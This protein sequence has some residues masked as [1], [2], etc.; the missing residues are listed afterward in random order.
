MRK[1]LILVVAILMG[2]AHT[3]P[4][5]ER[6]QLHKLTFRELF[7]RALKAKGD[8]YVKLRN[9]I[10]G[11]NE[12]A[13]PFLKVK[14]CDQDWRTAILA[15]AMLGRITDL[16]R[17]THYKELLIV[18]IKSAWLLEEGTVV[19]PRPFDDIR[20]IAKGQWGWR[21]RSYGEDYGEDNVIIFDRA[22]HQE[23]AI[24]FLIELVLKDSLKKLP[25]LTSRIPWTESETAY[26]CKEVAELLQITEK[27]AICWCGTRE[28]LP[29]GKNGKVL[30]R[31]VAAFV[32]RYSKST[33]R[34]YY[35][36]NL[37]RCYAVIRLG[38]FEYPAIIPA[39]IESLKTDDN[40]HVR[41]Y[42][43]EQLYDQEAIKHL[44][45]ALNDRDSIV[46]EAAAKTLGVLKDI[47]SVPHLM[48]MLNDKSYDVKR[49]AATAL[50]DINDL[51]SVQSLLNAMANSSPSVREAAATALAKIKFE[52]LK[53]ALRHE[54]PT[55]RE[56]ASQAMRRLKFQTSLKYLVEDYISDMDSHIE[57][58]R[59]Q[60][61]LIRHNAAKTLAET[62]MQV[63][64]SALGDK[65]K[66]AR[67][68]AAEMLGEKRYGR[69]LDAL[70]NILADE[71]P[72]VRSAAAGALG[73]IR[74]PKA[75][76]A[77]IDRLRDS[78][79]GVRKNVVGAL[80]EIGDSRAVGPIVMVLQK[81]K[82]ESLRSSA[83]VSLAKIKHPRALNPLCEALSDNNK[84]IRAMAARFLGYL[85]DSRA[86]GP[87][88]DVLDD[89]DM[90]IRRMA[91]SG[92]AKIGAEAVSHALKHKDPQVRR[93]ALS[94]LQRHPDP[95]CFELIITAL[96]DSDPDVRS[97]AISS[98]SERMSRFGSD[99]QAL[100]AV[101][102]KVKDKYPQVRRSALS[103]LS[104]WLKNDSVPYLIVGLKDSN[105]DVRDSVTFSLGNL[106]DQ[107]A[108]YPLVE[109]LIE[110]RDERVKERMRRALWQI[111]G[112]DSSPEEWRQWWDESSKHFE[113]IGPGQVSTRKQG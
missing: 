101:I 113:D 32:G 59:D 41:A 76:E 74:D 21:S 65:S 7:D 24:P 49:A 20:V 17:Y 106:K 78:D 109:A 23:D 112:N 29:L 15:E 87:L 94:E 91:V 77:L 102:N 93:A 42:A 71:S 66:L 92:L 111:T 45:E 107:R 81:H 110:E 5:T 69:A 35:N 12:G 40:A 99:K 36:R 84:H 61:W 54:N 34:N 88:V 28:L 100:E 55:I 95:N 85:E 97:M 83:I 16:E 2:S 1:I 96:E 26:S 105:R 37:A 57:S 53:D 68:I 31:D 44:R 48:D 3:V 80:G 22:L 13:V 50:G 72:R 64:V 75:T 79:S 90:H 9:A 47:E 18:P 58:L 108:V 14:V 63:L 8:E 27:T 82:D 39:L 56:S 62:N 51:K 89:E 4:G 67:E 103:A 25:A 10:I 52:T 33:I 86:V 60:N 38:R 98:L 19:G 46:R 30:H 43:A 70:I 104:K 6:E 11:R 73:R